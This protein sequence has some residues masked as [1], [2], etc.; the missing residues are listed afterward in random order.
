[1]LSQGNIYSTLSICKALLNI[2]TYNYL[3]FNPNAERIDSSD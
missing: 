1:M 2:K 3:L